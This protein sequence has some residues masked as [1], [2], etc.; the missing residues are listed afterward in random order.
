MFLKVIKLHH[1]VVMP[2]YGSALSAGLDICSYGEHLVPPKSRVC[3]PTGL[4]IQWMNGDNDDLPENY[5]LRIAPRS[6]LSVK[7]NIDIGAG[8][9]DVDYRGEIKVCFINHGEV[10]YHVKHGDRIAQGI[11]E[12]CL[13][14]SSIMSVEHLD[15]T[16]RNS[17]GFGSTGY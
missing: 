12:R 10:E 17:G 7:H 11:L 4:C 6:G 9:I 15:D 14:F 5:Y 16:Q 2:S 3:I 8:V 13:R 1:E